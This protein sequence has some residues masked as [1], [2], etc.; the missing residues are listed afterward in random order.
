[1]WFPADPGEI[2]IPLLVSTVSFT[3]EFKNRLEEWR[4]GVRGTE[5]A[6]GVRVA[7]LGWGVRDEGCGVRGTGCGVQG[8]GVRMW[9]TVWE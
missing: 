5:Y 4:K 3:K 1:M 7:V 9:G 2:G 8:C 6:R